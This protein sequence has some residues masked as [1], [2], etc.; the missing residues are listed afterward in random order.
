MK[1]YFMGFSFEEKYGNSDI[2]QDIF[3]LLL[4]I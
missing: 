4:S 2:D 1:K 3:V